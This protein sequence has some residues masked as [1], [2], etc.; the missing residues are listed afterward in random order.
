MTSTSTEPLDVTV[1]LGNGASGSVSVPVGAST[2]VTVG[3]PSDPQRFTITSAATFCGNGFVRVSFPSPDGAT[4]R[5]DGVE[6]LFF[7][8]DDC[9]D[10]DPTRSLFASAFEDNDDDG[11]GGAPL[12][13]T[14]HTA[15]EFASLTPTGT[16]CADND[17]RARPGAASFQAT[18]IN[19]TS[20]TDPELVRFDFN[21]DG[22][23]SQQSGTQAVVDTCAFDAVGPSCSVELATPLVLACGETQTFEGSCAVNATGDGCDRTPRTATQACR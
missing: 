23:L 9:D 16:D 13:R 10:A 5:V 12:L 22:A 1:S 4:V 14:C 19:G 18:K 21:C 17:A 7:V 3:G 20:D 11:F 2:D 15:A 8:G 6:L